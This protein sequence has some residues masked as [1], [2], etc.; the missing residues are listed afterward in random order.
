MKAN[1]E[2]SL[3]ELML[4]LWRDKSLILS[5]ILFFAISS[6][7]FSL[8][9][10]NK[11]LSSILILPAE[12]TSFNSNMKAVG[13][14]A[15]LAGVNLPKDND[16]SAL[17]LEILK[18]RSFLDNFIVSNNLLVP[19]IAS[20][21]WDQETNTLLLDDNIYDKNQ[22]KWTRKASKNTATIPSLYEAR[23]AWY[24]DIFTYNE[25]KRTGFITI[26]ITHYSPYLAQSWASKLIKDLN[27]HIREIDVNKANLAIDYL[28]NEAENSNS[29]HLKSVFF[30]L[31]KTETEKKMLAFS[32]DEYAYRIVDEANLPEKKSSPNRAFIC[33]FITL[34]G[35]VFSV[36][37]SMCRFF[38]PKI[39][40]N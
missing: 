5:V 23:K 32:Q 19:L 11:Y 36:F 40:E 31:I 33:I 20:R 10:P 18:S 24:E 28:N 6:V 1:Q 4:I 3:K 2:I 25:D 30:D 8:F 9:L 35:G 14:L 17:Y 7:I 22:K 34:F 29:E 37:V 13:G 39:K 12:Q 26:N 16:K 15:S 38:I 27:N 21:G